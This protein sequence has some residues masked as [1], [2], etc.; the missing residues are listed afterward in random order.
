MR[1]NLIGVVLSA[2][3]AAAAGCGRGPIVATERVSAEIV[4]DE[5]APAAGRPEPESGPVL[6]EPWASQPPENWPQIVLTN[7][8]TFRR[9]TPLLGASAFLV[10]DAKGRVL[11][12]TARHLLGPAGGVKP[13]V[14]VRALGDELDSWKMHPRT[15]DRPSAS[16]DQPLTARFDMVCLTVKPQEE[17]LPGF[18]LR[19]RARP[20]EAGDK[21]YLLGCPYREGGCKQNVYPGR[22][23][24]R[25]RG[26]L[27]RFALETPIEVRGFSGAPL[28]DENG[29]AAGV[30]TAGLGSVAD[31]GK[32]AEAGAEDIVYLFRKGDGDKAVT[33]T[34]RAA[35]HV[36]RLIR[37]NN[38]PRGTA[39]RLG[40]KDGGHSLELDPAPTA[41]DWQRE[42]LGVRIVVDRDSLDRLRGAVVDYVPESKGFTVL[43]P[44]PYDRE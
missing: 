30:L 20:V 15:V 22:V 27:F 19:P 1:L 8:A 14:S 42:S 37:Q 16:L 29:Q 40:V 32:S 18:P 10:R 21:I 6:R 28:I 34:E 12:V 26:P 11:A 33:V 25:E 44:D 36:R 13:A 43:A 35:E 7:D 31:D 2:S 9:S 3:M 39:L 24:R 23:T 4:P 17:E 38:A 5:P 41:R